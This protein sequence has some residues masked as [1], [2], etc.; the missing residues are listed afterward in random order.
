M[1]C[2][3]VTDISERDPSRHLFFFVST[4]GDLRDQR[5]KCV[6]CDLGSGKS[7][8]RSLRIH[9]SL[10]SA[11]WLAAAHFVGELFV[12]ETDVQHLRSSNIPM[13]KP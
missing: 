4:A 9:W 3:I 2:L 12:G 11:A 10:P 13:E 7:R 5:R 6:E 8:A 1:R